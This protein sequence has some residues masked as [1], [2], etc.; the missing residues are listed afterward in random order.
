MQW[1]KKVFT[2]NKNNFKLAQASYIKTLSNT[3]LDLLSFVLNEKSNCVK[4]DSNSQKNFELLKKGSCVFTSAH[5]GNFEAMCA[6]LTNHKVPLQGS[7]IPLKSNFWNT[8]LLK[9]RKRSGYVS[10]TPQNFSSIK[11][12]LSSGIVYGLMMDQFAQIKK[13]IKN[14]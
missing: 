12:N 13:L 14:D 2:A 8:I 9:L 10:D 6:F 5:Y 11:N 7:Y 4:M 1:K 3:I